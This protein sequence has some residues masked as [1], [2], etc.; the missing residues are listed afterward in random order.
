MVTILVTQRIWTSP[1][2]PDVCVDFWRQAYAA[3]ED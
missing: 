3:I 2:P 1:V